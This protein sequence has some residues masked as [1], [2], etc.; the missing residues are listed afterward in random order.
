[1]LAPEYVSRITWP[2]ERI[3]LDDQARFEEASRLY[4]EA[5][6]FVERKVKAFEQLPRVIFC[7]TQ[8]CFGDFGFERAPAHDAVGDSGS[9]WRPE[10]GNPNYLRH[11]LIHHLQAE[12]LGVIGR[13]RAPEWFKEGSPMRSRMI[14]VR[15]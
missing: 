15:S 10:A 4:E 12:R 2:T 1:M 11:E 6:A 13:W 9:S 8:A 3:C 14:S 5:V 7:S